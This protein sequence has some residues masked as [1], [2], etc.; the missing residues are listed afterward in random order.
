MIGQM[1]LQLCS[2]TRKSEVKIQ[3]KQPQSKDQTCLVLIV[4]RPAG[5]M[6]GPIYSF[7]FPNLGPV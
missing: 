6:M 5:V 4:Q 2:Y 3:C 1:S 7:L